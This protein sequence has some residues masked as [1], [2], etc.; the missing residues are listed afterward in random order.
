[1][2]G[3]LTGS[4][5]STVPSLPAFTWLV[6]VKDDTPGYFNW[7]VRYQAPAQP[8]GT[9]PASVCTDNKDLYCATYPYNELYQRAKNMSGYL[10]TEIQGDTISPGDFQRFQLELAGYYATRTVH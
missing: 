6:T 1:L 9:M 7:T 2:S 5:S 3:F 10:L 4:S 8:T